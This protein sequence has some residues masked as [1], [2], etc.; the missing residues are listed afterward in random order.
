MIVTNI[1]PCIKVTKENNFAGM[2][3][4]IEYGDLIKITDN[5]GNIYVGKYAFIELGKDVE[6]DDIITII[7]DDNTCFEIGVS[8]IIDIEE[9]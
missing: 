5:E 4:Y 7:R 2:D 3:M 9:L 6:E 8:Y 1:S